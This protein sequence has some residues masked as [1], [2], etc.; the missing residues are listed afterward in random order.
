MRLPAVFRSLKARLILLVLVFAVVPTVLYIAFSEAEAR[1]QGV[2]L[3]AIRDKGLIIARTLL[4]Y[5]RNELK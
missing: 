2:L 5:S 3:T 1:K 4:G